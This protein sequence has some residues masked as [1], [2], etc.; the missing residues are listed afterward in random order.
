MNI[1]EKID[2][3]LR[4]SE[5]PNAHEAEAALLKAREMMATY[6]LSITDFS[7]RPDSQVIRKRTEFN[8]SPTLNPWT[9]DL[10]MVVARH[11]CCHSYILRKKGSQRVNI[12]LTGFEVDV[13]ICISIVRYALDCIDNWSNSIRKLCDELYT[14]KDMQSICDSYALGFIKGVDAAYEKQTA[15]HQEWGLVLAP[16]KEA[17]MLID[18]IKKVLVTTKEPELPNL[19]NQGYRDG[20]AFEPA[21]GRAAN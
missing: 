10:C 6:K 1:R 4:L 15:V 11:N 14:E 17:Q 5:S 21:K 16:P 9:V 19:F 2:K 7:A 3:L 20:E 13:Y 18:S 12:G 8:C